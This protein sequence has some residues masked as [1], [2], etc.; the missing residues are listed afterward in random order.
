MSYGCHNRA[1]YKEHVVLD[2]NR[3]FP[4][5]MSPD[6]NYT[7]TELGQKDPHCKGCKWRSN[8]GAD[9]RTTKS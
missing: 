9:I 4:F 3:S 1:P 8:E 2:A 5:R 7:H 6:C